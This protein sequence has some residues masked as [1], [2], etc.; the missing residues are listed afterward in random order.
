MIALVFGGEATLYAIRERRH[1]WRSVPR[2]WVIVASIADVLI[3]S[4]LAIRGIAMH[5][6][7]ITVIAS[8]LSAAILFAF[9]LD[10]IKV[11]VFRRLQIA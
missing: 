5:P 4:V 2:T 1:L 7:Q 10:L 11:P 9:L 8:M 6:L 3:I